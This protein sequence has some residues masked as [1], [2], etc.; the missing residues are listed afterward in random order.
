MP[1]IG[2][3]SDTHTC[4]DDKLKDFFKDVDEIWH[5]GDFASLEN[6]DQIAAFKPLKAVHG[7][8][9]DTHIRS[10]APYIQL[11]EYGS[12]KILMM[13]IG[14]YPSRYDYRALNLIEAHRPNIFICGHS[15]I[16]KIVNDKK[17][18]MLCINPGAAG[19]HGFHLVRT[20]LRFKIENEKI[21][22]M[23]V[24]EWPRDNH[25]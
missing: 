2:L 23:E 10:S 14:G 19:N 22:E 4:F 25:S 9:D 1:Y 13:H 11:I 21:C 3:L 24:G 18:G 16:L 8:C 5:A 6:H 12:L 7:N 20:A 15:H 17:Y